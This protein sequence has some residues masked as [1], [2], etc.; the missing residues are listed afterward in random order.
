MK[1]GLLCDISSGAKARFADIPFPHKK[2][3]YW[4]FADLKAWSADAL[5]P[6]FSGAVPHSKPCGAVLDVERKALKGG[7]LALFDGQLVSSGAPECVEVLPMGVAAEKYPRCV[8]ELFF[9]AA[10]K[11]DTLAASRAENGAMVV[12]PDGADVEIE[13]AVVSKLGLSA[14][15]AIFKIGDNSRL[16]L[17]RSF[18]VSGGSFGV[19]MFGFFLGKNS[20]LELATFKYSGEAAHSYLRDDFSLPENAKIIDA[21][22]EFGLSPSRAERNFSIL[23]AGVDADIRALVKSSGGIT[24]DLRTSQMHKAGGSSSNLAVKCV[25]DDSSKAAFSGL[26]RVDAGAQKTKAY[27]SCRSLSLSDSAKTQAS[28]ILEIMANDV[29]CSHGCTVSKPDPDEIF[30]MNQRGL[31]SKEALELITAGF[32]RTTFERV[33][34]EPPGGV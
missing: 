6:H 21:Y 13:M 16:R 34:I 18:A 24:H 33:G 11:F 28:P 14:G 19:S 3:E 31:T 2:D 26:V 4:R 9:S 7:A 22:A 12:V 8:S 25:V 5:F 15:S 10:G 17:V 23:G 1:P 29:E 20:S 30:Y 27:Q 32:S